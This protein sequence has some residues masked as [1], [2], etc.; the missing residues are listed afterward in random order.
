MVVSVGSVARLGGDLGLRPLPRPSLRCWRL[1]ALLLIS[2]DLRCRPSPSIHYRR[3]RPLLLTSR[4]PSAIHRPLA[5]P[6]VWARPARRLPA[7]CRQSFIGRPRCRRSGTA[8]LAACL[9]APCRQSSI[10]RP[11]CRRS[12]TAPLA[13]CLPPARRYPSAARLSPLPPC[14]RPCPSP[15]GLLLAASDPSLPAFPSL[16]PLASAARCRPLAVACRL[17]LLAAAAFLCLPPLAAG[18]RSLAVCPPSPS[19]VRLPL[20]VARLSA[21]SAG[22]PPAARRLLVLPLSPA[23]AGRPLRPSFGSPSYVCFRRF[24]LAGRPATVGQPPAASRQ[25]PAASRQPPGPRPLRPPPPAPGHPHG[26]LPPAR[27]PPPAPASGCLPPPRPAPPASVLGPFSCLHSPSGRRRWRLFSARRLLGP[28]SGRCRWAS[29]M[30]ASV[31]L[32]L[33]FASC[34]PLLLSLPL[35]LAR[36]RLGAARRLLFC[37][38]LWSFVLRVWPSWFGFAVV[39]GLPVV[40][41]PSPFDPPAL[42]F[43]RVSSLGWELR[44]GGDLGGE[45]GWGS[46]RGVCWGCQWGAFH[47]LGATA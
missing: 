32:F 35:R 17:L 20:P 16:P 18:Y 41:L 22:C 19:A 24:C 9:P 7:V 37:A 14:R 11:R 1:L 2:V 31:C 5:L 42:G 28:S 47:S 26:R 4:S 29:S 34:V 45:L 36:L 25:P 15:M 30:G 10:G 3:R 27:P 33:A 23:S 12:G 8:L 43:F 6:P 46:G 38:F 13:A 21:V 39:P 40:S 44:F